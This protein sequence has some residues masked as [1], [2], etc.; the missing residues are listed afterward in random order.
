MLL[1]Y[2]LP[3]L[4]FSGLL[5]A[6]LAGCAGDEGDRVRT[7]ADPYEYGQR[8][9]TLRCQTCHQPDGAGVAGA[10]PPLTPP[11]PWVNDDKG[12]L[13]RLVLHGVRGEMEVHGE[14]YRGVMPG[15]GYLND[16]E[17][18]AVLT[19]TRQSFGNDTTAVSP[20]QVAAV[21]AANDAPRR[22]WNADDLWEATGIPDVE[23][24]EVDSLSFAP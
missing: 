17:V 13:I 15:F 22:G 14:I 21:R 3:A 12:R 7:A 9:Y 18:A 6:S 4:L 11:N 16:D 1:R 23:N 5:L 8:I 10:F 20:K 19:Y 24:V 2:C